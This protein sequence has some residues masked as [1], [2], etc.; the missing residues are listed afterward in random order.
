MTNLFLLSGCPTAGKSTFINSTLLA[1]YPN[2]VVISTDNYIE[3][4]AVREGKT[5]DEVFSDNI[6]AANKDLNDTVNAAIKAGKEEKTNKHLFSRWKPCNRLDMDR[7]DSKQKGG[8]KRDP[9]VGLGGCPLPKNFQ[10]LTRDEKY[11]DT[12]Q[13]VEGNIRDMVPERV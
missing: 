7:V 6:K 10:Q 8:K 1:L 12:G 9:R 11:D 4:V 3:A 5:Y 2:A 13:E